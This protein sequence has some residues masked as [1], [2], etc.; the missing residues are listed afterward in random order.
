MSAESSG[1]APQHLHLVPQQGR[2][3][4]SF[5]TRLSA[6]SESGAIL[7]VRLAGMTTDGVGIGLYR[8]DQNRRRYWAIS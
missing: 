6:D 2:T 5:K 3:H 8:I 7:V 4:F 1:C